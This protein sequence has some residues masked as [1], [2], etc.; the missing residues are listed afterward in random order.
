MT[1]EQAPEQPKET[2]EARF[3]SRIDDL[4][5]KVTELTS[6]NV[7]LA[8][9]YKAILLGILPENQHAKVE[10]LLARINTA[11][12][13][14]TVEDALTTRAKDLSAR[15]RVLQYSQYGVTYDMLME[16]S[17]PEDMEVL[18]LRKKAEWL[19]ANSSSS[20]DGNPGNLPSD[21]GGGSGGSPE[22]K[23][24]GKGRDAVARLISETFKQ[25]TA[26]GS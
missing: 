7:S 16:K 3:Q 19:E 4:E 21:K 9:Q 17:T 12:Q 6:E 1:T 10:E 8:G 11:S 5:N 13:T 14:A 15:E 20:K 22:P 25:K 24:E 2:D 26:S 18:A 23:I